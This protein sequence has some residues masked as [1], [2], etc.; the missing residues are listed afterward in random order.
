MCIVQLAARYEAGTFLQDDALDAVLGFEPEP[1]QNE[2]TRQGSP[3]DFNQ[4]DSNTKISN[5]VDQALTYDHE[6]GLSGD[7]VSPA[8]DPISAERTDA[9]NAY[10]E[11]CRKH[12]IEIADPTVIV[13][14]TSDSTNKVSDSSDELY[15]LKTTWDPEFHR[16]ICS[17]FLECQQAGVDVPSISG[18]SRESICCLARV[19]RA[20][21]YRWL[22]GKMKG[23][24]AIDQRLRNLF[25]TEKPH[26][27]NRAR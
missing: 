3:A 2:G 5:S 13:L 17:Y 21:F 15:R 25:V 23:T 1:H 26:L 22:K 9:S 19:H 10:K 7:D 14:A 4:D 18:K 8:A 16:I 6:R 20:D 24:S 11:E 27:K 12:G